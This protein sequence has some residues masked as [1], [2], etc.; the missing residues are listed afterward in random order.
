M[1]RKKSEK[2]ETKPKKNV[3]EVGNKVITTKEHSCFVKTL[4][5]GTEVEIVKV[6]ERGRF[7]IKDESGFVMIDVREI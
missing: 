4:P 1:P 3:C 7:H 2:A 6:D 5:A